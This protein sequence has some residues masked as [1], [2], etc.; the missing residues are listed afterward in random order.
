MS[1]QPLGILGRA[2]AASHPIWERSWPITLRR[3]FLPS[4]GNCL[5]PRHPLLQPEAAVTSSMVLLFCGLAYVLCAV[6]FGRLVAQRFAGI[7][8]TLRGSRNVGATNVAREAGLKLGLVTLL[9]DSLKGFIPV[10]L[11]MHAFPGRDGSLSLVIISAVLGHQFSFLQGFR[12][13]KGMATAL[14][15]YL[16][17]SPL[18]LLAALALFLLIVSITRFVSL[19]SIITALSMPL[20]LFLAG[21]QGVLVVTI[22]AVGGLICLKHRDNIGRL[23]RGE[24]RRWRKKER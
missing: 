20:F 16:A 4:E 5:N 17:V 24:E 11:F 2:I 23:I 6:P 15:V 12:G 22:L 1:G 3:W 10:F 19:G 18:C 9:L 13:G 21:Y 8:V 7:D 14:G